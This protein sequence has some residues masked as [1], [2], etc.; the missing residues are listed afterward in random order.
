MKAV[1]RS[2]IDLL[3]VRGRQL[4]YIS[5]GLGVP[6]LPHKINEIRACTRS[7]CHVVRCSWLLSVKPSHCCTTKYLFGK[8][9]NAS[10]VLREGNV[11]I[12]F[13]EHGRG[14]R[15]GRG[16][17]EGSADQKKKIR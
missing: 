15:V 4:Y 11:G 10:R 1:E 13:G 7:Y 17:G 16:R 9:L 5:A 6:H 2:E 8:F 12:E 14:W 3:C